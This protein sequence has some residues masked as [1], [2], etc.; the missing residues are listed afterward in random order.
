M[1][2]LNGDTV[3]E[4]SIGEVEALFRNLRAAAEAVN[5]V[6]DG[7]EK[8]AAAMNVFGRNAAEMMLHIKG[9]E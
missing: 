2:R 8:F 6:R 7:A 9:I 1:I 4:I 5:S 3:E